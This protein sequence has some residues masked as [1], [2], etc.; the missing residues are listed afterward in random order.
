MIVGT[1]Y[2]HHSQI[3]TFIDTYLRK[4]LELFTKS[5]KKCIFAGDFNVDLIKYGNIP[6]NDAFYDELSSHS[7]R[8][9]ILQPT[10]VTSRSFTLI[11][12]IFTNDLTCFS[13]GVNMITSISD[14]F[15]Q[16]S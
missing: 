8:P 11:D 15:S 5:K 7:F 10:R 16:F 4:T 13:T 12:N 2:R 1:I 9:L 3:K 6:V 14:H